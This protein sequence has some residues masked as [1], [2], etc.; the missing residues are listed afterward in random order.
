MSFR[1][2]QVVIFLVI[3]VVAMI[4]LGGLAVSKVKALSNE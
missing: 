3:W 2:R 1:E 4:F